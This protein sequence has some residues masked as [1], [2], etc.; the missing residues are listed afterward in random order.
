MKKFNTLRE[1]S[2]EEKLKASDPAGKY[3]H[4][5]VHSDN[6]KFA[7]KSKA[8]RIQMALAASYAAKGKSRNEEVEP[9]DEGMMND[10]SRSVGKMVRTVAKK[11]SKALTGGTDQDQLDALHKRMGL[12]PKAKKTMKESEVSEEFWD[13]E[14]G[15]IISQLKGVVAKSN[16][17][18]IKLEEDTQLEAW[19]QSKITTAED[20]INSV[21]DYLM[22]SKDATE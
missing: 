15:M 10:V 13:D 12:P 22:Y 18:I 3:I 6:P 8:K 17:I 2:L 4:D 5:F 19:V 20:S 1:D 14:G 9:V 16:A 7:G 21:H 11:A